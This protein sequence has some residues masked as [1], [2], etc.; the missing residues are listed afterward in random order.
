M[1]ALNQS[2]KKENPA[3]L[4]ELP[5]D[6][7]GLSHVEEFWKEYLLTL[8]EEHLPLFHV[9]EN[10]KIQVLENQKVSLEFPSNSALSEFESFKAGWGESLKTRLNNFQLTLEYI[11]KESEETGTKTQSKEENFKAFLQKNPLLESL[12]QKLELNIQ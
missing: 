4:D 8:K 6:S 10:A 11:V 12:I 9:L 5:G 3:L 1:A 7:F 2:E